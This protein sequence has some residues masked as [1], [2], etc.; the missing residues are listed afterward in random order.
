MSSYS[1]LLLTGSESAWPKGPQSFP[2]KSTIP[3]KCVII[4]NDSSSKF[5]MAHLTSENV[6]LKTPLCMYSSVIIW[7]GVLVLK[8]EKC[9]RANLF[10]STSCL[11]WEAKVRLPIFRLQD[12]QCVASLVAF[13]LG[14]TFTF[15]FPALLIYRV[16][17]CLGFCQPSTAK[18]HSAKLGVKIYSRCRGDTGCSETAVL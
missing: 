16:S 17:C 18:E 8:K 6:H 1:V 13:S 5:K 10:F 14:L 12:Q 7:G 4:E 2:A 3:C 15:L 11:L 9:C